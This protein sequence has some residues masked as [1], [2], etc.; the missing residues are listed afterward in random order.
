MSGYQNFVQNKSMLLGLYRTSSRDREQVDPA[1]DPLLAV[2][3][4]QD[5]RDSIES[6]EQFTANYFS[7]LVQY[8]MRTY[9]CCLISCCRKSQL[10]R[11]RIDKYKKFELAL[12]RLAEEHDIVN[13]IQLNRVSHLLHKMNFLGR[14]R[15]AV[16]YSHQ[17]VISDQNI[18]RSNQGSSS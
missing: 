14:Q 13:I 9:C 10:C 6:Q 4:K 8:T 1:Q 18:F 17:F 12:E 2:F 16:A 15:K 3:A 7:Y 11:R 5:Y